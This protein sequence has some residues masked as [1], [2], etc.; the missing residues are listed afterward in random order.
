MHGNLSDD[1][2]PSFFHQSE[3]V[4]RQ[5]SIATQLERFRSG[6][7]TPSFCVN[8]HL[9]AIESSEIDVR[10]WATIDRE[11]ALEA[12]DEIARRQDSSESASMLL[13]I[14]IGVKD[15]IDVKGMATQAGS[16]HFVGRVAGSDAPTVASLRR[17]GAIILGKTTTHEFAF[18]GTTPPTRNPRDLR[19]I[20][21]GSSGGSAA[22]L[23]A[24]HCLAAL[25]TDTAGSVRIPSAY[26]GVVGLKPTAGVFSNEGV[27]PLA[28]TLDTVGIMV[29]FA[30]DL[31][32]VWAAMTGEIH[33]SRSR[34][35]EAPLTGIR[36]G[37]PRNFFFDHLQPGVAKVI[38]DALSTIVKLGATLVTVELPLASLAANAA[39][40]IML[41]EA[42]DFHRDR[43]RS[44]PELFQPDV[45]RVLELAQTEPAID[46]VRAQRLG[47]QIHRE[48]ELVF[49]RVDVLCLPTL[50][51]TAPSVEVANSGVIDIDGA[52]VS[53]GEAQIRNNV[54]FNF[55]GVPALSQPC[56]VDERG[57]PVGLEWVAPR[58]HESALIEIAIAF[59]EAVALTHWN[60]DTARKTGSI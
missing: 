26:C 38:E 39:M 33:T 21:G 57:L 40:S 2:T 3:I 15:L 18:G 8:H 53:L 60:C 36:V 25:G 20:P 59:E 50:P 54:P 42:G 12:A 55:A 49:S 9:T 52:S 37:V 6:E 43:F 46:Y 17:A 58:N 45:L 30:S 31:P 32:F 41:G 24:G 4:T 19:T 51:C 1:E 7:A 22:A 35:P 5:T 44:A 23:A 34:E 48:I 10:A 11:G 16:R 13:G 29:S 27:V 28:P 56:G 14:P 47:F